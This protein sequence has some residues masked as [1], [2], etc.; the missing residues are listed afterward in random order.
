[1]DKK[2]V[3]VIV[4][5]VSAGIGGALGLVSGSRSWLVVFLVSFF[6]GAISSWTIQ[7]LKK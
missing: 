3:G 5:G 6:F 1:M 2:L 7:G 4:S